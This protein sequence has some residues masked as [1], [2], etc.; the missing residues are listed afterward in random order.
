MPHQLWLKYPGAPSNK[1]KVVRLA[2][3]GA[4]NNGAER[5]ETE[6]AKAQRMV[7]RLGWTEKGLQEARK[8]DKRRLRPEV[9]LRRA[10]TI[11]LKWIA[12]QLAMGSWTNV[13]LLGVEKAKTGI[14]FKK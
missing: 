5:R 3:I 4:T 11:R 13:S 1:E 8:G 9:R 7:E 14:N 10:T 2:R 12:E 6:E